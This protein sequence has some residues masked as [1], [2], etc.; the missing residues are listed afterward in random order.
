MSAASFEAR[1]LHLTYLNAGHFKN[2]CEFE[3]RFQSHRPQRLL[4]KRCLF[5]ATM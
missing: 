2:L 3:S 4:A 1:F 5:T